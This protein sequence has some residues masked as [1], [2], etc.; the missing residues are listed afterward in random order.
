MSSYI[1]YTPRVLTDTT[2]QLSDQII[3][4]ISGTV[5]YILNFAPTSDNL[6]MVSVGGVLYTPTLDFYILG[7]EI[8]FVKLDFPSSGYIYIYYLGTNYFRINSVS[9]N[10]IQQNHLSS[11]LKFFEFQKFITD[12]TN[13]EYTLEFSPGSSYAILVFLDDILLKPIIDYIVVA[14][15]LTLNEVPLINL[16]IIVRNLGFKTSMVNYNIPSE[17]I[18]YDKIGELAVRTSKINNLAVTEAKIADTAVSYNKLNTTLISDIFFFT[19]V[20]SNITLENTKSYKLLVNTASSSITVTL[21]ENPQIGQSVEIVDYN[22]TFDEYILTIA[23]NGKNIDGYEQNHLFYKKGIH[24]VMIFKENNNWKTIFYFEGVNFTGLQYSVAVNLECLTT[25]T[26]THLSYLLPIESFYVYSIT[27]N[28]TSVTKAD[29]LILSFTFATNSVS[30]IGAGDKPKLI[31]LLMD[32][33]T[34]KEAILNTTTSTSTVLNFE[35]T[36]EPGLLSE[37]ITIESS[38]PGEYTVLINSRDFSVSNLF[39]NINFAGQQNIINSEIKTSEE[40]TLDVNTH[41]TISVTPSSN[42]L[43]AS[44]VLTITFTSDTDSMVVTGSGTEPKLTLMMSDGI[45]TKEAVF[46]S[47]TSSTLVFTYT[48][49]TTSTNIKIISYS[50]GDKTITCNSKPFGASNITLNVTLS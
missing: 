46:A 8:T 13:K 37:G 9:D 42:A 29:T 6:L 23:R 3:T 28:N 31:L 41:Y 30:V 15:V 14:N 34:R 19:L 48:V 16:D 24:C 38:D 7:N 1:G 25:M 18:T 43:I 11:E 26:D 20:N 2:N 32:Q 17:S 50:T 10:S 22:D 40:S 33:Y 27:P 45:T 39:Q 5:K 21:P 36:L 44:D 4:I 49:D 47:S 12:G 35:Y